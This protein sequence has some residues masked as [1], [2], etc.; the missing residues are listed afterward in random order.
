MTIL[1]SSHILGELSKIATHY[2]IISS[3]QMVKELSSQELERT[4]QHYLCVRLERADGASKFLK[5]TVPMERLE[6]LPEQKELRLFGT[7]RGHLFVC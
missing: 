5:S 1:I 6:L 7:Q 4:C 2:G 3:G